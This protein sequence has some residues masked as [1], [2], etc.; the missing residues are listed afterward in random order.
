MSVNINGNDLVTLQTYK[1][2]EGLKSNNDDTRLEAIISSVSQL[3]KTYC[4]NSLVDYVTIDKVENINIE[5]AGAKIQ[6][7]ESPILSVTSV[8]E[9]KAGADSYNTLVVDTD[10]HVDTETDTIVR[11]ISGREKFW[12]VGYGT[13]KLTYSAGYS[14]LPADLKLAVCDLVTYYFKSEHK[15]R[16]TIQGATQQNPAAGGKNSISFPDHIK[17]VLDFYKQY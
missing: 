2:L 4:G 15:E 13:V 7:T 9:K 16:R 14:S 1:D 5:F 10:Y 17:R 12:E 11:L 6:T 3:V 8:Q